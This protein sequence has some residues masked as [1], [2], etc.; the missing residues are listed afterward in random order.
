MKNIFRIFL[1]IALFASIPIKANSLEI[2]KEKITLE[3]AFEFENQTISLQFN[4]VD[5]SMETSENKWFEEA[6]PVKLDA[7]QKLMKRTSEKDWLKSFENNTQSF[8]QKATED[9]QRKKEELILSKIKDHIPDFDPVKELERK[10]KRLYI[11]EQGNHTHYF[12]KD[13]GKDIRLI[14]FITKEKP[15]DFNND[16]NFTSFISIEES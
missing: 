8:I 14:T 10:E 4:F 7:Y 12:L 15:I 9:S 16:E 11:E 6:T 3:K 1:V 5:L 2:C 13:K